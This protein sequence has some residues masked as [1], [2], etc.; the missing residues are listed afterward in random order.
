MKIFATFF[1]AIFSFYPFFVFSELRI[2]ITKGNLDPIPIAILKFNSSKQEEKDLSKNINE[3]IKNNLSRSGL[4]SVLP[5][6][7]FLNNKISFNK[8]PEFADWK[9]TTAQGLVHGKLNLN[10]NKLS[11]E[12]RLW[13]IFSQKQMIAQQLVT[14]KNNWRRISHVISDIIYQRITGES[15]YFDSRIVYI[16]ESGPKSARKKRLAI[17]DQ[18][19]EN[20]KFLTDGS[21]LALTPRFSPAAQEIAYLSYN[22]Q[23][24]RIYLLDLETGNQKILGDF[25][26]MTF[27][28]R[29]SP[30]GKKIIMSLAKNG[31]TD[32]Y[33]M[34][35]KSLK[36]K[37]ANFLR[38]Y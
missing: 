10:G 9:L 34:D 23:T 11:I 30:D 3:V 35:L 8:K 25:P 12:F 37:K 15:G 20:H 24:P 33:E 19:G 7:I 6:K 14:E 28:P 38:G 32:I 16:S 18:D 31:N 2:D 4:F 36:D 17:I 21:Y 5:S 22:N 26:G 27:S 29:Y 1:L 13:D